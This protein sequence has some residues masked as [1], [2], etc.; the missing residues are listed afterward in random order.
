MTIKTSRQLKDKLRNL[1]RGDFIKTQM[2]LRKYL[3]EKD[4]AESMKY[5]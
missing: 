5:S 1:S 2:L 4:R 3:M